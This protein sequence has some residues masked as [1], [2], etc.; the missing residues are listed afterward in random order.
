[1]LSVVITNYNG[2]AL[3]QKNLPKLFSLLE[4]TKHEYEVIVVDDKSTDGSL[5]VLNDCRL[6]NAELRIIEKEKNEG[7]ASTVD[8]G[9]RSAKGDHVFTLK[10]DSIPEK[11][12]Y[13]DLMLAHFLKNEKLFAVTAALKTIENGKEEI[14]GRGII[15]F[16][17]GFFLHFRTH[18]DYHNWLKSS[19]VGAALAA[20]HK[21]A[22][23]SPAPTDLFS[24]W[25]DGS[26]SVFNKKIYE[27]LG[28]F[29]SLYNPFYWEDTDL[30]YR[31]WK[32][33]YE[34]EFEPKAIL[35]HDHE[36]GVIAKSYDEVSRRRI[37]LRNQFIFTW[38]NSDLK[39]FLI[40]HV[41]LVY[42]LLVA[43][44]NHDWDWF[45][46][47]WQALV[48]IP[49]IWKKRIVQEKIYTKSDEEIL[50]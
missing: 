42:H 46:S 14:R 48:R 43:L 28:G 20:A 38:K 15:T 29:D 4:K 17:K 30:G 37:T 22:G 11:E 9:I 18:E 10:T 31:A 3:L 36:Q 19:R 6:Q 34:V 47:F 44:R 35:L 16:A 8:L 21:R 32:S 49:T 50:S 23:T 5:T 12:D 33:G 39:Y 24:S 1:M 45:Y 26:A 41:W 2:A 13:F 27:K 25:P 7:F 40:H